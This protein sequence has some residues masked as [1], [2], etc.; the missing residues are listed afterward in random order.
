MSPEQAVGD[1]IDLRTDIYALGIILYECFTYHRPFDAS[2]LY[3]LLD[4]HVHKVPRKPRSYR[5]E[6]SEEVEAVIMRALSKKP[7]DRYQSAAQMQHALEDCQP[8]RSSSKQ[9]RIRL[10]T[11][12]EDAH[13][14]VAPM[15]PTVDESELAEGEPKKRATTAETVAGKPGKRERD[16][17]QAPKGPGAREEH[18]FGFWLIGSGL[19]IVAVM[20]IFV[21]IGK[22]RQRSTPDRGRFGFAVSDASGL[23]TSPRPRCER[24]RRDGG[25]QRRR[26]LG[27]GCGGSGC[28]PRPSGES[29]PG[30]QA[31][32]ALS[33]CHCKSPGVPQ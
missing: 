4:Q 13:V 28:H 2:S 19:A 9:M 26:H 18:S 22:D 12:D 23:T 6:I 20:W 24:A 21:A 31:F 8:T 11:A 15:D 16:A 30:N 29:P 33:Q 32:L 1:P 5:P 10:D 27:A 7:E 17:K 25:C 14:V 3:K